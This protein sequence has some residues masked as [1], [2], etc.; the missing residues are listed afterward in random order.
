MD[1]ADERIPTIPSTYEP[2]TYQASQAVS[3]PLL[4][5]ITA[6]LESRKDLYDALLSLWPAED[7]KE[8]MEKL[9]LMV[10]QILIDI[11]DRKSARL[12]MDR[13]KNAASHTDRRW[14]KRTVEESIRSKQLKKFSKVSHRNI[15]SRYTF[16][17]TRERTRRSHTFTISIIY[18]FFFW[19]TKKPFKFVAAIR[20]LFNLHLREFCTSCPNF[21]KQRK[22]SQASKTKSLTQSVRR[23]TN[24][25]KLESIFECPKRYPSS[26]KWI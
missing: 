9:A 19:Y 13:A 14:R 4:K 6:R 23:G 11:D 5:A 16:Y 21:P 3:K 10:A 18:N 2:A 17:Q 12:K 20:G 24:M 25:C 8:C 1:D 7:Q 22:S 26:L 15:M